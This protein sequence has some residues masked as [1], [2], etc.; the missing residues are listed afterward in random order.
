[1]KKIG[2]TGQNGFIGYHLRHTLCLHNTAFEVIHFERSYFDDTEKLDQ[3]VS[4]C[5]VIVH[6]AALNRHEDT[7]FLYE[8]NIK[9]VERLVGA[10][11]RTQSRAHVLMTSSTQ[12]E[13]DNFYGRSKRTGRL[14]LEA[15]A[16]ES[17]GI[18][19]GL[20]IPNVF[21]PFGHPFYNSV[22]ATF[23]HQIARGQSPTIVDDAQLKLIYVG[24]LVNHLLE[25]ILKRE[26]NSFFMI[27][28]TSEASVS[29]ILETIL[30]NISKL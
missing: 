16:Q 12:E 13:R 14:K 2:I 11:Q 22:V 28:P 29:E 9:L 8:T 25:S 6:L 23:C 21:G 3:F 7:Q 30:L 1:M 20:I 24:D 26:N 27:T 5:D 15:W 17:G 19:T 4:K 18:F 10:L